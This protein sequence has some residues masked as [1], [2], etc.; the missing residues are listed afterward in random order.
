LKGDGLGEKS[1]ETDLGISSTFLEKVVK[2]R[3]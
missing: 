3:K 2:N 1:L